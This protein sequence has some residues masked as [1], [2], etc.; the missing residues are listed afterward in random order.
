MVAFYFG[1]EKNSY[2]YIYLW[3]LFGLFLRFMKQICSW[4]SNVIVI[5][6]YNFWFLLI[7]NTTSMYVL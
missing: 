2:L 6:F 7:I 3:I 1:L 4:L 5:G